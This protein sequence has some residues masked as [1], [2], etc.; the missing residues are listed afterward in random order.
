MLYYS[1][2]MAHDGC[3]FYYSLWAN[4]CPVTHLTAKKM[5]TSKK[6]K[7]HPEISPFNTSAPKI[8]AICFPVPEIWHV[9]CNYFHYGLFFALLPPPPPPTTTMPNSLKNETSKTMQKLVEISSFYTC[10]PKIIIRW[11]TVPEIW[12]TTDRQMDRWTDG[13]SDILRWLHHLKM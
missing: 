1:W 9:R 11:C 2:D 5:K 8:M 12:C 7:K 6:W 13:K 10:V 4:F 3:N